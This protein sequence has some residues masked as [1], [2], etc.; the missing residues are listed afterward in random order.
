[1]TQTVNYQSRL[2]RD[3]KLCP[4]Q[5]HSEY[6]STYRWHEYTG[7]S[8]PEVV[9]RPPAPNQFGN[10]FGTNKFIAQRFWVVLAKFEPQVKLGAQECNKYGSPQNP[11]FPVG[12]SAFKWAPILKMIFLFHIQ[13]DIL[14]FAVHF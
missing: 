5:L 9:R 10:Q 2:I 13:F 11:P 6:R 7:G 4:L 8:R 1:M 14:T 3:L 12:L